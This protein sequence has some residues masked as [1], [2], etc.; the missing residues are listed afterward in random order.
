[1]KNL[2][3]IFR[4]QDY[5][6]DYAQAP[7]ALDMGRFTRIY[8]THRHRKDNGPV[9]V[10][11]YADFDKEWGVLDVN[12]GPLIPLGMGGAF[13]EYGTYPV[14]VVKKGK[15]Y[16]MYYAGWTRPHGSVPFTIAIGKAR[17]DGTRF[18]KISESPF[19]TGQYLVGSMRMFIFNKKEYLF[20]ITGTKW[21]KDKPVYKI[22][23][24]GNLLIEGPD[25]E[26]QAGP[27]VHYKDGLYH[28]YFSFREYDKDNYRIGYAYSKDLKKWTRNNKVIPLSKT[29]WDSK[30]HHYAHYYKGHL[31]VTG[32]RYGKYGFGL[33]DM[34][35]TWE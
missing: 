15:E 31:I 19:Y 30:M 17:G 14:W 33:F 34:E 29:G 7:C 9:S 6:M 22:A 2:G 11:G 26:C 13:D 32:N 18:E 23:L 20:Y 1:M 4:P 10:S 25:N 35:G 5:G 3:R 24:D 28:M 16:E 21:I 27:D 12:K 8:F